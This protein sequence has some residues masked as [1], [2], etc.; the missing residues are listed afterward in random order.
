MVVN[1]K[2]DAGN[3]A[4]FQ[5]T[6]VFKALLRAVVAALAKALKVQR[7][8]EKCFV[9]LVWGDVIHNRGRRSDS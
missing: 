1:V 9:A 5:R 4:A 6:A 8:E 2:W 7:V 3:V